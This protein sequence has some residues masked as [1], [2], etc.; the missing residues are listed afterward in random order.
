MI[1]SYSGLEKILLKV[2]WTE[3]WVQFLWKAKFKVASN[4]YKFVYTKLCRGAILYLVLYPCKQ[5]CMLQHWSGGHIA[6]LDLMNLI[7]VHPTCLVLHI[8]LQQFSLSYACTHLVQIYIYKHARV[9]VTI[10]SD[11][12][13]RLSY[14]LMTKFDLNISVIMPKLGKHSLNLNELGLM[15]FTH[16]HTRKNC[17]N[18]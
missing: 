7:N 18:Y 10:S 12:Q 17:H 14:L 2:H 1:K 11:D 9:R 16:E 6:L 15:T 3:R 8:S 5:P 4:A 13:I